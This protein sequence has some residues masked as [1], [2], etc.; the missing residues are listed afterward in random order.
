MRAGSYNRNEFHYDKLQHI[1]QDDFPIRLEKAAGKSPCNTLVKTNTAF[2]P[3]VK[4]I[5]R[6]DE[7]FFGE[8]LVVVTVGI[9][10]FYEELK[11]QGI[12]VSH[13]DW[14]PPAGG[15]EELAS[16]LDKLL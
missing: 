10:L 11:N 7:P 9:R 6:M 13:V 3:K 14:Q 5:R 12:K 1:I 15:D 4:G 2:A 8:E 16:L